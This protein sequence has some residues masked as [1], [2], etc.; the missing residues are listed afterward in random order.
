MTETNTGP[1]VIESEASRKTTEFIHAWGQYAA[2]A[3]AETPVLDDQLL[4]LLGCPFQQNKQGAV[5]KAYARDPDRHAHLT[6]LLIALASLPAAMSQMRTILAGINR[7]KCADYCVS[8]EDGA[9]ALASALV[10]FFEHYS[11]N[12]RLDRM[13]EP[14]IIRIVNEWTCPKKWWNDPP[15]VYEFCQHVFDATW[16]EIALPDG[17]REETGFFAGRGLRVADIILRDRPSFIQGLC[18]SQE[19]SRGID[20]P[21]DLEYTP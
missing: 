3:Q 11:S 17:S 10:R 14:D 20:L 1:A 13:A 16:C 21:P 12:S 7:N 4:A 15:S 8:T 2:G 18:K 5:A 19:S 6:R 9:Y